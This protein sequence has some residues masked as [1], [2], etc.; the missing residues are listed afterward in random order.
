MMARYNILQRKHTRLAGSAQVLLKLLL[1]CIALCCHEKQISLQVVYR[2]LLCLMVLD[3]L[4]YDYMLRQKTFLGIVECGKEAR[5]LLQCYLMVNATAH[6]QQT[7]MC[8]P[9]DS[10]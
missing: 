6:S 4:L 10:R 9:E 5:E 3:T 2:G 1:Q 8:L 7:A